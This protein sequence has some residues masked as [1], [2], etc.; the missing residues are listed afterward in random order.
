MAIDINVDN[1]RF[2]QRILISLSWLR[3][4]AL[5]MQ[6]VYM[7]W[8]VSP[9]HLLVWVLIV[10]Q[11]CLLLSGWINQKLRMSERALLLNLCFDLLLLA[12]YIYFT[13][14]VTN[15]L[16]SL[17]L[18]PVVTAAV[19]LK[20][21][22]ALTVLIMAIGLYSLL[23]LD[24][25]EHH[26]GHNFSSH[27]MGMWLV[28]IASGAL[29]FYIASYLSKA[30]RQQQKRIQQHEQ[31]QLRNDY[32]TALGLSAADAAHQLNTPLSTLAVLVE[33]VEQNTPSDDIQLMQQQIKRC[34]DIT[35]SI[36]QQFNELKSGE[37]KVI[38]IHQLVQHVSSSFRL[39]QPESELRIEGADCP[40]FVRS[41]IGL[42]SALLNLLDNAAKASQQSGVSALEMAVL[43]EKDKCLIHITDQGPG[44]STELL[45]DYGWRPSKEEPTKDKNSVGIGVGTLISNA[46]IEYVGGR[47]SVSNN[48]QG[49]TVTVTLP[50]VEQSP[51]VNV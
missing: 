2:T 48:Q 46:S 39:L 11:L 36:Q 47:L 22:L 29:L 44:L 20:P 27:L 6:V 7:L 38:S 24:Q 16:I 9:I 5:I 17:F 42:Q 14:G 25:S 45:D 32:L 23:F 10:V 41:H 40:G 1:K 50:L 30:I 51:G 21:N 19:A 28:F 18:L 34:Q 31:R 49:A 15:P 8:F 43:T 26:H 35:R 4:A 13:G 33:E 3:A 37:F 12:G